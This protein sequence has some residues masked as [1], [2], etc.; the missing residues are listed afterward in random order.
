[1]S[2]VTGGGR[3][4]P[5]VVADMQA[6][7]CS[8]LFKRLQRISNPMVTKSTGSSNITFASNA[9]VLEARM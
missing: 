1:M 5:E 4:K 6:S 3:P 8:D 2:Y 9:A 7:E